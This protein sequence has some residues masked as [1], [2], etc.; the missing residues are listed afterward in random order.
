MQHPVQSESG[1]RE[2]VIPH[3]E[4]VLLRS[5]VSWVST[6]FGVQQGPVQEGDADFKSHG[7]LPEEQ[8]PVEPP[9]GAC[10]H[11]D[12]CKHEVEERKPHSPVRE[13]GERLEH[14]LRESHKQRSGAKDA[15]HEQH[16]SNCL[17]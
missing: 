1:Q 14:L 6:G 16:D 11:V 12:G 7:C 17:A 9:L 5:L 15:A 3:Q 13:V 8:L 2:G 10:R 4:E